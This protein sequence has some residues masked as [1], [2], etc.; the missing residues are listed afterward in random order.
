MNTIMHQIR[1]RTNTLCVRRRTE[2]RILLCDA[3]RMTPSNA[4]ALLAL[5]RALRQAGY[6]FMTVTPSTHRRIN[7][8]PGN[9]RAH[10]LRGVFGWSRP[11][12]HDLL[13]DGLLA[14]MRAAGVLAGHDDQLRSR[15][16]LSTLGDMLVF[17][18]AWPTRDDEAVF[19]GPDTYR[20]VNALRRTFSWLGSGPMRALDIGCGGGAAALAIARAFPHAEVIGADVNRNALELAEVNRRLA[21]ADNLLLCESDLLAGLA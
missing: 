14:M 5:G 16:R 12:A 7:G 2:R 6:H 19:F 18:S 17:H 1:P 4:T 10:D 11:F 8:R 3:K 21:G 20:F 13:P 9:E 15:V